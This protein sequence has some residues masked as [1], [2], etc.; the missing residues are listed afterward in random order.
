MPQCLRSFAQLQ[1]RKFLLCVSPLIA[2][3]QIFMIY[4]Q[5]ANQQTSSN[6]TANIFL[7]SV[8]VGNTA[9]KG[10]ADFISLKTV[11]FLIM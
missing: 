1:I 4:S 5:N 11:S 10:K 3:P 7:Y 9:K 6:Q 8:P 2:N